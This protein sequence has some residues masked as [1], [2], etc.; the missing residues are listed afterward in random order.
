MERLFSL[1]AQ[2]IYDAILLARAILV[3][4]TFLS[5]LLFNPARDFLKK[6]QERVKQDIDQ[7]AADKEEARKLREDYESRIQ[8]IQAEADEIL[9]AAR[10]KALENETR[11]VDEAKEEA[12]R[13]LSRA[14]NQAELEKKAAAEDMKKEMIVVAS[15]MAGK[16]VGNAVT[17]EVSDALLED[18]L[19]E[20]GEETWRS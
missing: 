19:K 14:R 11:I 16:L 4:F 3:M 6:R 2:L 5:Y 8:N 7:A 18:T 17:A 10:K 15:A 9:S 12:A 13:I 1:D 20:I